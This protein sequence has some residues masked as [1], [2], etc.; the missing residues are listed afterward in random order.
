LRQSR[1]DAAII[2]VGKA[3][4]EPLLRHFGLHD[5]YWPLPTKTQ[6]LKAWLYFWHFRQQVLQRGEPLVYINLLN[7]WR[8]DLEALCVGAPIRLGLR[9]G[10]PRWPFLTHTFDV[11]ALAAGVPL[12]QTRVA[13]AFFQSFG[14]GPAFDC[15]PFSLSHLP[16]PAHLQAVVQ[17]AGPCAR[18]MG[19]IVGSENN[20]AKRWPVEHWSAFLGMVSQQWPDMS[21]LLLGT[22]K[23]K[24]IAQAIA[25]GLLAEFPQARVHVLAGETDLVSC[26][27]LLARC[28]V[29]VGHDTGGMHLASALGIPVVGL[30]G[31]GTHPS[32]A[33]PPFHSLLRCLTPETDPRDRPPQVASMSAIL[34]REVLDTLKQMLDWV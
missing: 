32:Y 17:G 20:P 25:S 29:V 11:E 27:A 3:Y 13:E 6:G 8:S 4:F 15:S 24:P 12:H 34:P 9:R 30:Y 23:D 1:P 28:T 16:L 21:L 2:L 14:G 26:A 33:A 22:P 18:V 10:R 19:C 7:S 5:A 31:G